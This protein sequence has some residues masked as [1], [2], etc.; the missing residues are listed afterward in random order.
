MRI[1]VTGASGFLGSHLCNKLRNEFTVGLVR[2]R[3]PSR[4]LDEA[5]ANTVLVRGD[6][7]DIDVLR[8]AVSQYGI[9]TVIHLGALASVK[10]ANADPLSTYETNF[11]GTVNVLE[12]CRQLK[13]PKVL[14]LQ[15][16][17]VFGQAIGATEK[18]PFLYAGPYE[19]SKAAQALMIE[20]Y[21]D[22][23]NLDVIMPITSNMYGYDEWSDRIVPN[24]IRAALRGEQPKVFSGSMKVRRQYI[25]VEDVV[26]AILF[27]LKT[28]SR[29]WDG[30][31]PWNLYK[32]EGVYT[33]PGE[34]LTQEDVVREI[35][36]SF[37]GLEPQYV[38]EKRTREL[39]STTMEL[40]EF[41]W[42]PQVPFEGGI[43]ETV[44]LFKKY[45]GG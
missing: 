40:S 27:L 30:G 11:M 36:K 20:S 24:V 10:S 17:K 14:I 33:I 22:F 5:L 28:Y 7:R 26:D 4:W 37:P 6:L 45:Q 25:Y 1:F 38:D 2:D 39:E 23:Y 21:R 8:R 3:L 41:G 34:T 15:S 19:T 31:Y 43:E 44:R 29:H 42:K 12:V 13:I 16:D 35:L 18:S 9:D 32:R